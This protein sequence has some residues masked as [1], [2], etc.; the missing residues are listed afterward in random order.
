MID[1]CEL[2]CWAG[3]MVFTIVYWKIDCKEEVCKWHCFLWDRIRLMLTYLKSQI[4]QNS[5]LILTEEVFLKKLKEKFESFKNQQFIYFLSQF[6]DLYIYE[7]FKVWKMRVFLWDF[8]A[9]SF[10]SIFWRLILDQVL[11]SP[12]SDLNKRNCGDPRFRNLFSDWMKRIFFLDA[13]SL[14]HNFGN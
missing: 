11:S 2:I 7:R 4:N 5:L 13:Q 3:R 6:T 8:I 1:F 12:L 10:W 9:I 14:L